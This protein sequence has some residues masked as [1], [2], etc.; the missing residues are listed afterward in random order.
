ALVRP[1]R[2][3]PVGATLTV[4][5]EVRLSIVRIEPDG[6]RIV[7]PLTETIPALLGTHGLP[8]L[9][10]YIDRHLEPEPGDR[11]R[12]QTVYARHPGS[13]AART[14]GLPFSEPLLQQIRERGVE[15]HPITLHVGPG[16]FRP[17]RASR[18]QDHVV[19]AERVRVSDV[20]AAAVNA[21]RAGGRRI[22]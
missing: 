9:P 12:Y 22:V 11:D 19:D 6:S 14:G 17:I 1:G 7:D 20:T 5:G 13:T 15:V 3:C 4:G 2:R 10:P 16:T 8:P 18:V 21:A